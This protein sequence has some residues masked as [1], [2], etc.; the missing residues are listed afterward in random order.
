MDQ[1]PQV[2]VRN[3]VRHDLCLRGAVS[4][5]PEGDGGVRFAP[6]AGAKDG[7]L[8]VDIVDIG[9]GGLGFISLV[10]LP[11]K[12]LLDVR[13]YGAGAEGV[14]L[15]TIRS[16]VQRVCM[17]DRRPAYLMGCSFDNLTPE[18]RRE[19]DALLI[20]LAGVEP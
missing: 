19:L 9:T 15:L 4:I 20:S 7:W 8:E 11:R 2:I 6:P 14:L 12:T 3:S 13:V 18:C 10:F 5:V 16:R 1:Q 17:T